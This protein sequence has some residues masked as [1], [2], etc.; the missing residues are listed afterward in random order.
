MEY[1]DTRVP[2]MVA[3]HRT[4]VSRRLTLRLLSSRKESRYPQSG[5]KIQGINRLV[6]YPRTRGIR[7]VCE[8]R[9]SFHQKCE[10]P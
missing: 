4:F 8:V 10:P 2:P 9:V 6:S 1:A 7:H 5:Y 3:I